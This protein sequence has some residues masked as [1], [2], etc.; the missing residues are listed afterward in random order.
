MSTFQKKKKRK[1]RNVQ[2]GFD[3]LSDSGNHL[4]WEMLPNLKNI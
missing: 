4:Y 1:K 3:H 2:T